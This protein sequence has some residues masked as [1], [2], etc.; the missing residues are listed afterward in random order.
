MPVA[1]N[2]IEQTAS[3]DR[4]QELKKNCKFKWILM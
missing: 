3:T 4:T 2:T 1:S